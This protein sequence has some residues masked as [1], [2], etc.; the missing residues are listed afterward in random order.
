MSL[1]EAKQLKEMLDM[2][3]GK[4]CEATATEEWNG[5]G[6]VLAGLYVTDLGL[7]R[8]ALYAEPG[9]AGAFGAATKLAPPGMAEEAVDEHCVPES[10]QNC[11]HELVNIIGGLLNE[12]G[13]EH[14]VLD[15]IW[16][17]EGIPEA[18]EHLIGAAELHATFEVDLPG[19]TKGRVTFVA[20]A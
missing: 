7:P 3:C 14:V 17:D 19:Y 12:V 6:A 8:V 5:E 18:V 20:A 16:F 9:F 13:D 15:D 4:P 2:L 1:P 11:V 10:L